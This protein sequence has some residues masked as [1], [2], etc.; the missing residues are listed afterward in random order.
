MMNTINIDVPF[1]VDN[2]GRTALTSYRDHLS[3]MLKLLLFTQ[4]GERVNRPDFGGGCL[5][6]PFSPNSMELAAA[7]RFKLQA[8]LQAWLNDVLVIQALNVTP[9]DSTLIVE[10]QYQIRATGQ[11]VVEQ[12]T[13]TV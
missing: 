6:L 3:D 1:H 9:Q 12:F 8:N 2:R 4:P 13:Q 5:G 7:L 10:V 11:K